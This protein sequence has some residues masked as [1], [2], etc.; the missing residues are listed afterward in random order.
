MQIGKA[1]VEVVGQ[2]LG[3]CSLVHVVVNVGEVLV[4][5]LKGMQ[6]NRHGSVQ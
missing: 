1:L 5:C 6:R 4:Q 3:I 2:H